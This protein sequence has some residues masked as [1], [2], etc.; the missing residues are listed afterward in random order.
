[1][2]YEEPSAE[3]LGDIYGDVNDN[4]ELQVVENPYY[5]CEEETNRNQN[6]ISSPDRNNTEV[7]TSRQNDYYEI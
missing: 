4:L 1:M 3:N 6:R 2:A 5:E 7:I